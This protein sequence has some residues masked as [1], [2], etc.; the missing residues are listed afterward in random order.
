MSSF[1]LRC[2]KEVCFVWETRP[3][4]RCTAGAFQVHCRIGSWASHEPLMS[5]SGAVAK[6]MPCDILQILSLERWRSVP[7]LV[8]LENNLLKIFSVWSF[9][10]QIF[11]IYMFTTL[12]HMSFLSVSNTLYSG[13]LFFRFL[14]NKVAFFSNRLFTSASTKKTTATWAFSWK[15]STSIF[16]YSRERAPTGL[17]YD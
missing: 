8:N 15:K 1:A 16:R 6:G 12:Y 5:R 13:F 3:H 17:L 2:F 4:C 11:K 9:E 10:F 14:C 7:N